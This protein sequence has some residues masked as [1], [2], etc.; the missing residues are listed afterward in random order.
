MTEPQLGAVF[1]MGGTGMLAG[2]TRWIAERADAVTLAARQPEALAE[3]IGATAL[4]L[5]WGDAGA[6]AVLGQH[7]GRYDLA[8]IWL[9]DEATALARPA[10]DTVRAGGRVIRLHGSLSADP[11]TRAQR[12]PDPREDVAQQVVILGYHPD[13]AAEEGKRWLSD[14]EISGGV[15]AAIRDPALEALTIGGASGR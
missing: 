5:D 7:A 10:A 12:D 11:A 14:A 8:V 13:P 4:T 6:G 1:V 3:E 9:H 2:A 15:I